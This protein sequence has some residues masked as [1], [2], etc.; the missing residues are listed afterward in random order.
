MIELDV[1]RVESAFVEA[2]NIVPPRRHIQ[3]VCAFCR[4]WVLARSMVVFGILC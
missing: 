3:N 1:V 2:T 4:Y